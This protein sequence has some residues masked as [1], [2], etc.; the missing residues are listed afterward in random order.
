MNKETALGAI[1]RLYDRCDE[2]DRTEYHM[3]SDYQVVKDYIMQIP[4][5]VRCGHCRY[6]S[7]DE[8]RQAIG[9]CALWGDCSRQSTDFCSDG[10]TENEQSN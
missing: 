1:N 7:K 3:F 2:L 10:R 5:I 6:W 4:E 9:Y 8:N